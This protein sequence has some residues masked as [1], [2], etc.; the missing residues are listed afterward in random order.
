MGH[1]FLQSQAEERAEVVGDRLRRLV[2]ESALFVEEAHTIL[3]KMRAS[4]IP[5]DLAA[6]GGP[7]A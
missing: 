6:F 3:A 5:D 7:G 4:E 1:Y 2:A